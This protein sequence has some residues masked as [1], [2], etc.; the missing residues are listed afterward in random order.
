MHCVCL[1]LDDGLAIL[2][3]HS[4]KQ[5]AIA[6]ARAERAA[7][8]RV[9]SRAVRRVSRFEKRVCKVARERLFGVISDPFRRRSG[10][11][12]FI[13]VG[14]D[15]FRHGIVSRDVERR[16]VTKVSAQLRFQ[17]CQRR[18]SALGQRSVATL[19][20]KEI[21]ESWGR[22]Y[23]CTVVPG[24]IRARMQPCRFP[25]IS[26]GLANRTRRW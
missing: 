5:L 22:V 19:R 25:G 2:S 10:V 23:T 6:S 4:R 11:D 7:V 14:R 13:D 20:K 8:P 17:R 15:T 21:I 26:A 3:S 1:P 24:E 9:K 16:V 12:A 18:T